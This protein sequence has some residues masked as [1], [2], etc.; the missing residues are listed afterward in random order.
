MSARSITKVITLPDGDTMTIRKLSAKNM[1]LAAEA[2]MAYAVTV[3]EKMSGLQK[4]VKELM[5][6]PEATPTAAAEG[7]AAEAKPAEAPDPLATYDRHALVVYGATS[8]E[9]QTW[10]D[11]AAKT[12][13]VDDLSEDDLD[14]AAREILQLSAPKLFLTPAAR[15]AEQKNA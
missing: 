2:Q 15:A 7:S 10:A 8:V 3:M 12:A 6:E 13:Y 5:P 11:E 1:R 4:R 14:V 9:G